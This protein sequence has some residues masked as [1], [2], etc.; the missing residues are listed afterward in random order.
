MFTWNDLYGTT[1]TYCSDII[2]VSLLDRVKASKIIWTAETN[3][4][5]S[6]SVYTK[7]SLDGGVTYDDWLL[8][9]NKK[10][11]PNLELYDDMS[12]GKIQFK[13]IFNSVDSL[14]IPKVHDI[15]LEINSAVLH[16]FDGAY[17]QYTK[18]IPEVFTA[19]YF[20]KHPSTFTGVMVEFSQANH[21]Y[22]VGYDGERF[23]FQKDYRLTASIPRTLP[24]NDFR[25]GVKPNQAVIF[26]DDY[27]E[28]IR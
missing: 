4:Y 22:K 14:N 21:N 2:S 9:T 10:P 26:T 20:V 15:T 25:I 24:T 3:T 12:D 27:I 28:I 1:G 17:V 5:M 16:L 23:Y 18:T 13:I 6:I 8:C 11:I 19:V 7:V